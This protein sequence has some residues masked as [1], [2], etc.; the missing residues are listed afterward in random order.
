MGIDKKGKV[1][2]GEVTDYIDGGQADALFL[3]VI[4]PKS[5]EISIVAINRN[6]MTTVTDHLMKQGSFRLHCS[7]DMVMEG[8]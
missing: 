7:T 1:Y 2:K 6:T 3:A 8:N 5:E 4:N